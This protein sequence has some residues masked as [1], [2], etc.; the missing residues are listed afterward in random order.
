MKKL[1]KN[2]DYSIIPTII[3]NRVNQF[4]GNI[5]ALGINCIFL[6]PI[7]IREFLFLRRH[8]A[9][10]S[11]KYTQIYLKRK[12]LWL[13][14]LKHKIL[15]SNLFT[16]LCFTSTTTHKAHFA[17][18][19]TIVIIAR[20]LKSPWVHSFWYTQTNKKTHEQTQLR[21]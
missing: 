9:W 20:S 2:R 18:L 7:H 19:I 14:F 13:N 16:Q 21:L 11:L 5:S 12:L 4:Q 8:L 17:I 6:F 15:Y 10:L 3:V 1:Y